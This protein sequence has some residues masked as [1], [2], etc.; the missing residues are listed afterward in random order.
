MNKSILTIKNVVKDLTLINYKCSSLYCINQ[1]SFLQKRP[2]ELN[3]DKVFEKCMYEN[4][5]NKMRKWDFDMEGNPY[6]CE[7]VSKK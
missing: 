2:C 3:K 7:T 1:I 5:K 4:G 6:Y